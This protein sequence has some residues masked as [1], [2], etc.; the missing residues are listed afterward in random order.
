MA[1][2]SLTETIVPG[3]LFIP[4]DTPLSITAAALPDGSAALNSGGAGWKA[5][6]PAVSGVHYPVNPTDPF[7][8]TFWFRPDPV[9]SATGPG[10]TFNSN[11]IIM[12][13]MDLNPAAPG[14][15]A[16][17]TS[18]ATGGFSWGVTFSAT[19]R[20]N[21]VYHRAVGATSR[22]YASW[23]SLVPGT[24]EM[25][26]I[27]DN[28]NATPEVFVNQSKLSAT[29]AG[30]LGVAGTPG[31]LT[32]P[33]FALGSYSGGA[34]YGTMTSSQQIARVS[35]FHRALSDAEI[36]DLYNAGTF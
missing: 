36:R 18:W 27:R 23:Y 16:Q 33:H 3:S 9:R 6:Q 32:D 12:G 17:G 13:V 8:I 1:T 2:A 5:Y 4:D 34:S 19:N 25:Y 31:A 24:M 11:E 30:S 10:S 7:T 21:M 35:L 22:T 14:S 29:F 15:T 28:G 26:T 20:R